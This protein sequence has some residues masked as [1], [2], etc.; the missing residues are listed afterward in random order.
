MKKQLFSAAFLTLAICFADANDNMIANPDFLKTDAKGNPASW[1]TYNNRIAPV[2]EPSGESRLGT[3]L[4]NQPYQNAGD[5]HAAFT[6]RLPELKPG[7]YE[8]SFRY[9]GNLK[10]LWVSVQAKDADGKKV[11]I[12]GDW[13]L[14]SQFKSDAKKTDCFKYYKSFPVPSGAKSIQFAV[15]GFGDK[16]SRFEIS[17]PELYP[18]ED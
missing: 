18:Q 16:D 17:N 10:A 7:K 12:L 9:Y 14:K 4:S 6:Q 5:W 15:Q 11:N 13:F 2:K 1:G 8:L 3:T